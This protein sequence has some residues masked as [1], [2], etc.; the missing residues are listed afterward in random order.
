MTTIDVVT[1]FHNETNREQAAELHDSILKYHPLGWRFIAVDNTERN[2]GF[3]KGCNW[4]AFHPR[5]KSPIIAFL[6]PDT[7]VDGPFFDR[8][9]SRLQDPK[10][11]ITGC[12]FNKPQRELEIWGVRDWVC[13]AAMFVKRDF[14]T[15]AGGFDEGFVWAW[16]ETDL[17]RRAQEQGLRTVSVKLPLH[18]HSPEVDTEEDAHYKR[19]HFAEGAKRYTQKWKT[20][21][22]APRGPRR[23]GGFSGRRG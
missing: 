2:R 22:V 18:H 16:E 13:G 1:V 23:S 21:R 10:T 11:V 20:Q 12:R 15:E 9:I 14:F 6:N 3:A 19:D 5:A 4:G 7:S 17:I 8:V